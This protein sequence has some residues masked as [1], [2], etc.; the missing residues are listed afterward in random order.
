MKMLK[1]PP[2]DR[3][4][5]RPKRDPFIPERNDPPFVSLFQ[6]PFRRL[7]G[8]EEGKKLIGSNLS[9]ARFGWKKKII[10]ESNEQDWRMLSC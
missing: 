5:K 8:A 4:F 7:A 3:P 10:F 1:F 6:P 9:M 2:A